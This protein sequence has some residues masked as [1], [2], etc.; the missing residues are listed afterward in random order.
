MT[1]VSV[2]IPVYNTEKYLRQ[3]LD[4]VVN[5]TFKDIEIICVD[6]GSTDNSLEILKEYQKNDSRLII[7]QQ[8]HIGAGEAR[9]KGIEVAK[10][11]YIGFLDSDDWFEPD[12]LEKMHQRATKFDA[13]MVV[14]NSKN[15]SEKTNKFEKRT[16]YYPID[17]FIAP[18]EK[19]FNYKDFPNDIIQMFG[20][21]P[22]RHLF[23]K[24]LIT[25]NNIKFQNLKSCNDVYFS[26]V[27][28][29]RANRIVVINEELIVHRID[30]DGCITDKRWN[31][32][33]NGI[34][35]CL[36]FKAYLKKHHLY[37]N[38][39]NNGLLAHMHHACRYETSRCNEFQYKKFL[40]ELKKLLPLSWRKFK[41][42]PRY[43][44][45]YEA[46]QSEKVMLWGASIFLKEILK[47][48]TEASSNILGVIDKNP[49]NWGKMC[50]NYKIYPPKALNELKPKE[51][52]LTI[53]NNNETIY[54]ELKKEFKEKYPNIKLHRNIFTDDNSVQYYLR[55][56][57]QS[58]IRD[59]EYKM[60][61]NMPKILYPLYLKYWYHKKT[62]RT[63]NLKNP[64]TFNEK[65][66]WL[67]L[68][69]ST[70]IKTKLADKYL[71]RDW[72]KEK[73]GEEYLIPL[74]GVWEKADDIDFDKL[75][76]QFV[77]KCNHGCGYNIIVKDKAK[78][79][80]KETKQQ[81]TTWLHENF[82]FKNGLELHYKNIKPVIIAEEYIKEV[83]E[84]AIDYKFIC[85]N[86]LPELCWIT[87]KYETIHKR[88]F[89]SLPNW[90]KQNIEYRD[91]GAIFDENVT[92]KPEVLDKM[93]SV[94]KT[95]A[96]DFP[97]VRVDLYLIKDK[98]YFGEMTFT[99]SSGGALFFPYEW[100]YILGEKVTLPEKTGELNG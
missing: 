41:P 6:D 60:C 93:L 57:M 61:K 52:I 42:A 9:N 54:A 72:V 35:A 75:P 59:F 2:I 4:S 95:L 37:S 79:N 8:N 22:W 58:F 33:I 17:L 15:L 5:Q 70:P 69:D 1:E 48:E 97:L 38:E 12:M 30:H 31:H 56:L 3:C 76:N 96:K 92:Q 40:K 44:F 7:L 50:G 34:K 16:V 71:V 90:E 88:S 64:K 84:S 85:C 80:I 36:D 10:G 43:L 47:N 62:N 67:K 63:L 68:Y 21:E 74:L 20:V 55:C 73:I 81:L 46:I 29:V 100:N 82:A 19:P 18:L 86:G 99:S 53:I 51:V 83:S 26:F 23:L 49:D 65:I 25:N 32:S 11:K 66:Q 78:L 87:N 89:Y 94:V 14:C 28:R 45:L 77:L 24:E 91:R 98:I 27:A 39:L 13:D